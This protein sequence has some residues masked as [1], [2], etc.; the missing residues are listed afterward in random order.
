MKNKRIRFG[1]AVLMTVSMIAAASFTMI[2]AA[3][4]YD[5]TVTF[6]GSKLISDFAGNSSTPDKMISGLQ[7]GSEADY[8]VQITN[9]SKDKADWYMRNT[10]L[11][12]LEDTANSP[13]RNGGYSYSLIYVD[14]DGKEN[15]LITNDK[16]GGDYDEA[17]QKAKLEGLH[18]ATN[19]TGEYFMLDTLEA[20]E[21]AVVKLHVGLDGETEVNSY[22]DTAGKL[23]INFAVEVPEKQLVTQPSKSAGTGS[24]KTG[25]NSGIAAAI[26]TFIASVLVMVLAVISHRRSVRGGAGDE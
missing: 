6:D 2:T 22:M 19:A 23:E 15:V 12:S 9:S 17:A 11:E 16:F 10:I 14:P 3:A 13:A 8:T 21:S 24:V 4:S 5:G 1:F 18:Q 25:D 7:P 20:G 26:G